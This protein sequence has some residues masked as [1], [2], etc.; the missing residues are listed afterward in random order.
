M[1]AAPNGV[2]LGEQAKTRRV[3]LFVTISTIAIT[4]TIHQ[5]SM[6]VVAKEQINLSVARDVGTIR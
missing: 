6:T 5:V 4:L 1:F 3:T 2:G